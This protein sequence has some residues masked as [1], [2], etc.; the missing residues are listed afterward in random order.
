MD[1][2]DDEATFTAHTN[3]TGTMLGLLRPGSETLLSVSDSPGRKHPCTV[4]AVMHHGFWVGV[5][6]A[7]PTRI[8]KAAWQAGILPEC[9][10]Y[11]QFAAEP[12]FEHGRLDALLSGPAGSLYVE[13]KNVTL[14][15][16]CTAQFPDAPSERARKHMGEL[17]RLTRAG[18]RA[19]LFFAVQR[20][21]GQCFAPAEA[22]DPE[23]AD[24]FRQ[25]L[26]AGV[27]A[28]AYVVDVS[29]EGYRLGHRLPLAPS[30]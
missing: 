9:A 23:Y 11:T 28:W 16:D 2:E 8:L 5:N 30:L 19:A 25:A 22:V 13:T 18:I 1:V 14:V 6:T 24:L 3:N 21:D 10:G 29:P 15:E 7:M 4:E 12:R 26:E 20:P 27:E 17:M